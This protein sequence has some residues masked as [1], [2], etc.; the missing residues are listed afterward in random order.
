MEIARQAPLT[1]GF[2][3]QEYWSGLPFPPPGHLSDPGIKP[4]SLRSPA[5]QVHSLPPVLPGKP[6]FEVKFIIQSEHF[7]SIKFIHKA[8]WLPYPSSSRTSHHPQKRLIPMSES[9]LFSP[10]PS[11]GDHEPAFHLETCLFWTL[12]RRAL[13]NTWPLG[14][15]SIL[16]P[17]WMGVQSRISTAGL[18]A[19]RPVH[20]VGTCREEAVRVKV[21]EG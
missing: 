7:S 6:F 15:G 19:Q 5:L 3:R 9:P 14:S 1:M 11:S 8:V 2:S 12:H 10:P 21:L 20:E 16:H 17:F 18:P 13:H 4:T